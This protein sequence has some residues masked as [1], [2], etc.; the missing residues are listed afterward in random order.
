MTYS[1]SI[2]HGT[3]IK[4][5]LEESLSCNIHTDLRLL[6]LSSWAEALSQHVRAWKKTISQGTTLLELLHDCRNGG[7][8]Y[9]KGLINFNKHPR[10]MSQTNYKEKGE[11]RLG[12]LESRFRKIKLATLWVF[13]SLT[14]RNSIFIIKSGHECSLSLWC[15]QVCFDMTPKELFETLLLQV[16]DEIDLN[17]KD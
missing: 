14:L 1:D 6:T 17:N 8:L 10:Q 7:N 15:Y 5:I 16:F 3:K 9:G 12:K 4:Y 11:S 2:Q 13:I